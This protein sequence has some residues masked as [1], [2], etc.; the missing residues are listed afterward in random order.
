L[1]V[2]GVPIRLLLWCC[3]AGLA[4]VLAE[5][6]AFLGFKILVEERLHR[7]WKID[8]QAAV[9]DVSEEQLRRFREQYFDPVL[10]W[11]FGP[12]TTELSYTKFEENGA[13]RSPGSGTRGSVAAY[14]DSFTFGED[15]A[16]DESWPYFLSQ[17]LGTQVDNFGVA[18]YG[19]DQALLRLRGHL[20]GGYRP[21][22]AILGI[23]S[24]NIAR[25]V[26]VHRL[27][28]AGASAV[29]NFK[30]VRRAADDDR[31]W[32]PN[33]LTRL[34]DSSQLLS[35]VATAKENDFWFTYNATRPVPQFPYLW[36]AIDTFHYLIFRARRWNNLWKM[37]EPVSTME[38][39]V[40]EFV[41]ISESTNFIPVLVLIPMG[42]DLRARDTG[43]PWTYQGFAAKLRRDYGNSPL[44]VID[45][46]E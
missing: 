30:P 3:Y 6:G 18:G 43:Q 8:P 37:D 4:L 41:Q 23:L 25:V 13:R 38:A 20:D 5:G 33:P 44:I 9:A 22:M 21:R 26:N 14:G 32:V 36:S 12:N 17:R 15:V 1:R 19:T 29:L 31:Y 42:D 45:V 24:E 27:M 2:Q 35:A 10:G 39:L 16:D 40:E 11:S 28:Y 46:L 34:D 7:H